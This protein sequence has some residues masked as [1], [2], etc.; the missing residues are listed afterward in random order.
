MNN[1]PDG[2][3]REDILE[4]YIYP[5]LD[6]FDNK[7]FNMQRLKP[8]DF[9]D[10]K[11]II[12]EAKSPGVYKQLS[13]EEKKQYMTNL[14]ELKNK[15]KE[16]K[17][18]R[19]EEIK[20]QGRK[21]NFIKIKSSTNGIP[22]LDFY[23]PFSE[24]QIL[25]SKKCLE[26]KWQFPPPS[27]YDNDIK[28][29]LDI[30]SIINVNNE[31]K[32][33]SAE[34]KNDENNLN[35]NERILDKYKTERNKL[36]VIEESFKASRKNIRE[37]IMNSPKKDLKD[38][39]NII[40]PINLN[41]NGSNGKTNKT[42]AGWNKDVFMNIIN[43]NLEQYENGVEPLVKYN[44]G[45]WL[46]Y[47]DFKKT[48]NF[49][50]LLHNPKSFK[51]YLN[52]DNTWVFNNDMFETNGFY[53]V[54]YLNNFLN[55]NSFKNNNTEDEYEYCDSDDLI[56]VKK[57]KISENIKSNL[58]ILFESNYTKDDINQDLEE[59]FFY[60]NFDLIESTGK[61]LQ[62]NIILSKFYSTFFNE[63]LEKDKNYFLLMKSF[64]CPFGYSFSVYSDHAIDHMDYAMY[65]KKF[66]N[67]HSKNFKIDHIKLEKNK[68]CLISK[69]KIKLIEKTFFKINLNHSDKLAKKF[70]EM[71]LYFGNNSGV[72][73]KINFD[74]DE[75][76]LF[77]PLQ[78]E[79]DEYILVILMN[80][81]YNINENSLDI[82]ILY[83]KDSAK[84]DLI[85]MVDPYYI[86]DCIKADKYGIIFKEFFFVNFFYKN[87]IIF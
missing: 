14:L 4:N 66:Y 55:L 57:E 6:F 46:N 38:S 41:I 19:I 47:Q 64:V 70:I 83:D 34:N 15:Q 39:K 52:C 18:K 17:N 11:K 32:N 35:R 54:I 71:F 26:N 30:P 87:L 16:L 10:I 50:I 81:P 23:I 74:L 72:K 40:N 29:S 25:I 48:F 79:D 13:K 24:G 3:E 49:F 12:K 21:Y 1:K 28:D 62:N 67:F 2:L 86:Y 73:K 56:N 20:K 59:V 8:L 80:P 82:N 78:D 5:V 31:L 44:G 63:N 22:K 65:L 42:P 68:T 58:L 27:Y 85:D 7:K 51:N 45:T 43:Y 84:I 9:S 75:K 37:S 53:S 61:L 76:I 36:E 33:I 69:F 60:A 77:D